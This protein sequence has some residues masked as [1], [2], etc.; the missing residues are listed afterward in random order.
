L[1]EYINDSAF[2]LSLQTG[3]YYAGAMYIVGLTG[4][5]GSGKS[6]VSE[7]F[8]KLGV[9]VIDTDVIAHKLTVRDQPAFEQI[10]ATFGERILTPQGDLDRGQLR[11]LVFDNNDQRLVLESILHP[12]IKQSVLEQ[13]HGLHAAYCIVVVPLLVEKGWQSLVDRI[14]V[15]DASETEQR[16]RVKTRNALPDDQIDAIMRQQATRDQRLSQA[17]DVIINN[18]T[19]SHVEMQVQKLH[20]KYLELARTAF[21]S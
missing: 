17:D 9:P 1:P 21:E 11:E 3:F 8:A 16:Q 5:I 7:L 10:V 6:I 14:L 20:L 18:E 19:L 15:V 2:P 13:I 12:L 4:G